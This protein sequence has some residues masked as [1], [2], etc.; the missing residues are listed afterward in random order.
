VNLTAEEKVD[1]TLR[2]NTL[3]ELVSGELLTTC[4]TK[5]LK[6]YKEK[7]HDLLIQMEE[8]S[9]AGENFI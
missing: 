8:H 4:T 3:V 2:L 7:Q 9:K 6:E 1:E 5:K